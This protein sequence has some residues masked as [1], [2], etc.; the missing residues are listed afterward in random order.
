MIKKRVGR[1]GGIGE[2][3]KENEG[4]GR[5]GRRGLRGKNKRKRG[6]VGVK[7]ER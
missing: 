1:I 2:G 3:I 6:G 4:K 5:E 7:G